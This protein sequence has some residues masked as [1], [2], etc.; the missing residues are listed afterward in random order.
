MRDSVDLS[1]FIRY[2]RLDAYEL[3][4]EELARLLEVW[5]WTAWVETGTPSGPDHDILEAVHALQRRLAYEQNVETEYNTVLL[6]KAEL[7]PL[8]HLRVLLDVPLAL[9]YFLRIGGPLALWRAYRQ[10]RRYRRLEPVRGQNGGER[11][12][13][14]RLLETLKLRPPNLLKRRY[15][16][17]LS[18]HSFEQ[19]KRLDRWW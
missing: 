12:Y 18:P 6:L 9:R 11:G 13:P 19:R 4:D 1:E 14:R 7:E 16:R 8:M 10:A 3:T 15:W 5:R 17:Q 2:G